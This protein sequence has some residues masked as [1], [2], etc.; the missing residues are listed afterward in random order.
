V[1]RHLEERWGTG[2]LVVACVLASILGAVMLYGADR[3]I[4]GPNFN[5]A[6]CGESIED[7]APAQKAVA[8]STH[9]MDK[10]ETDALAKAV[11]S[12]IA[13]CNKWVWRDD[14]LSIR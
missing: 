3:A 10:S 6:Q 8:E 4:N 7:L 1:D 14:G 11:D 9:Y 2:R 12:L 5:Y 13:A